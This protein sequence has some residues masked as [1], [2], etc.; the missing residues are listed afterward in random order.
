MF[1]T[2]HTHSVSLS[3]PAPTGTRHVVIYRKKNAPYDFA[4][5]FSLWFI[6][7]FVSTEKPTTIFTLC[8]F[9]SAEN[10]AIKWKQSALGSN[11][12]SL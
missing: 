1:Q 8:E 4:H 10:G 9:T 3:K 11:H 2:Q 7:S 5:F 6:C 12:E